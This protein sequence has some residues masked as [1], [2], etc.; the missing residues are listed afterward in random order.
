MPLIDEVA[1]N[2]AL[3]ACYGSNHSSVFPSSLAIRLYTDDP[4][5]S[6]SELTSDGGYAAVIVDNDDTTFPPATAG[7]KESALIDFGTSTD[8][9]SDV[10]TWA[11]I[12]ADGYLIEAVELESPVAVLEADVPVQVGLVI[13]HEDVV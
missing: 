2:A 8:A 7:A 1:Q 3:D 12:E 13:F 11:V 6:G 9:W 5:L 4:R 10:A